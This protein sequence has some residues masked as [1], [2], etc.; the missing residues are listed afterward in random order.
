AAGRHSAD[1]LFLREDGRQW[2]DLYRHAFKTAVLCAGLPAAFTFHGLRHTYASQLIQAGAP[3]P[4]VA[5]QLGHANTDTVSRTYGHLAPQIRESEVRQRFTILS[6]ENAQL[7]WKKRKSMQR[8]RNS[9]HGANWRTYASIVDIRSR[10]LSSL[11][12]G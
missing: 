8:W 12:L 6:A 3:L 9:L 7:A 10:G 5:E 11:P 1:Q 2:F 4:V